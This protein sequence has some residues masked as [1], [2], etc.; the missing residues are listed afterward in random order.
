M[1]YHLFFILL[2]LSSPTLLPSF[3]YVFC[4][5][6]FPSNNLLILPLFTNI[7]VDIVEI[8]TFILGLFKGQHKL[9]LD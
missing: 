2:F 3:N 7:L 6:T 1:Y 5:S 4:Y 8:K 9:C